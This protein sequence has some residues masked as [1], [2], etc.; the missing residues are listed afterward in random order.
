MVRPRELIA[1]PSAM[2]LPILASSL[3]RFLTV[4]GPKLANCGRFS[5]CSAVMDLGQLESACSTDSC[6]AFNLRSITAAAWRLV[7]GSPAWVRL[8]GIANLIRKPWHHI[9]VIEHRTDDR[10]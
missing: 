4:E 1:V 8:F 7:S 5:S 3:T 9:A 6:R 10:G 2:I